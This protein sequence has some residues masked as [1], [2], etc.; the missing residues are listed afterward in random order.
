VSLQ[1]RPPADYFLVM[2]KRRERPLAGES[3]RRWRAVVAPVAILFAGACDE[4]DRLTFPPP[5]DG[6]G[7]VTMIDQP[8]ADDTTVFAGSELFVSGRTVDPD[9]VDSVYFFVTG[10]THELSPVKPNPPVDTV[11]FGFEIVTFGLA[12]DTIQVQ[13]HGVDSHGNR[14]MPTHRRIVVE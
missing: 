3:Y 2:P 10:G 7:P 1:F 11:R 5:D 13:I 4:R 12:G 9:G 8:L 14:G 6:V